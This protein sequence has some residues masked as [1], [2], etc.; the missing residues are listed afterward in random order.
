[1]TLSDIKT[2]I[3]NSQEEILKTV[4]AE[5]S[6][7]GEMFQTLFTKLEEVIKQN[8]KLVSKVRELEQQVQILSERQQGESDTIPPEDVCREI[9]ERLKRQM[10]VIV[11]GL[12][13]PYTGSPEER[14][15]EERRSVEALAQKI[16]VR[17]LQ[18]E[19]IVRIGA[20][21]SKKP[22]LLRLKC[23]TVEEKI[24]LL[25]ASRNLRKHAD[26]KKVFINPDLT[27]QQRE[28]AKALRS[29]LRDRRAAGENVAIRGG[30]IIDASVNSSSPAKREQNFV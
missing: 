22:R 30:R 20:L 18:P 8:G 25:R 29:E 17:N 1:L 9:E 6:K 28:K 24:S 13:E 10:Y 5:I 3:D 11:S 12:D 21:N 15:L 14:S 26:Y 27:K 19:S 4:K 23:S 7:N 16:G 2:L